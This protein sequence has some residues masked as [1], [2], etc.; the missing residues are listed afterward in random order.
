MLESR[1]TGISVRAFIS[2]FL[3]LQFAT[4]PVTQWLI[5]VR[6]NRI[7]TV[8]CPSQEC[9]RNVGWEVYSQAYIE[10]CSGAGAVVTAEGDTLQ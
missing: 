5:Q 8:L 4:R 2:S 9:Q 1:V 3:F 10:L 7:G 6:A